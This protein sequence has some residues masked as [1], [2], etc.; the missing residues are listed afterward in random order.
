MRRGP[1]QQCPGV[2][3]MWQALCM[4]HPYGYDLCEQS[5][6][7]L[8]VD[9]WTVFDALTGLPHLREKANTWT[10][11]SKPQVCAVSASPH[12]QNN[13]RLGTCFT[14]F[15]VFYA[16]LLGCQ[17]YLSPLTILSHIASLKVALLL[18]HVTTSQSICLF[19]P[20]SIR[21]TTVKN[22]N[23][24]PSVSYLNAGFPLI[25]G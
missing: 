15:S 24:I 4:T 19:N 5:R 6:Q 10:Q 8:E 7:C 18:D 1:W 23:G 17:V 9:W 2:P 16:A 3:C 21:A 25:A 13:R 14:G 11:F 20:S 12:S 22:R